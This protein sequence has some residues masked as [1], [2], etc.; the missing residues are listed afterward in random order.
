MN[1]LSRSQKEMV[2]QFTGISGASEKSAMAALAAS[3]WNLEGAFEIFYS[4]PHMTE[5]AAGFTTVVALDIRKLEDLFNRYKDPHA[6]VILAEGAAKLCEDLQVDPQDVV[7]LV[8]SWHLK[9][10]TMCEYSQQEFVTGLQS[11]GVDSLEKL[12]S[13][14]PGM[15][16]ELKDDYKFKEIYNY[17]FSWA[18]EKGQ[19]S[20]ALDTAVGMWHL[21]FAAR[22]WPYVDHWCEFLQLKHNRAISKDTWSQ[23][24]EFAWMTDVSLSNYD[25]EGAWPYLIDEFVEYLREEGIVGTKADSARRM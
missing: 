7:T 18:R 23:L 14:L 5:A 17:A 8:L 25:E 9:A 4:N 21:L 22:P 24:L 2:R 13:L 3:D 19:K 16:A 20:L 11:L 1:R 12:R 10:A 6:D 15:R